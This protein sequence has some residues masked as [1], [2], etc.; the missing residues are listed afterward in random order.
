[1][2]YRTGRTGSV[3]N[4]DLDPYRVWYRSG[5]LYVVGLDHKSG[6]IRTFA[7]DRIRELEI[8]DECFEVPDSFDFDTYIG[9]S[10]GV[11]ADQAVRVRILFEP[12]WVTYVEERNWHESQSFKKAPGGKIEL[13]MD[14]GS[15]PDLRGWIL[16]FGSGAEVL[17]PEN[18]RAEVA[19]ELENARVR[20]ES[21]S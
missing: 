1:M 19:R 13:S 7:V 3:A 18:L 5:G 6:E 20:Y 8:A 11:I 16:S 10:F 14:V 12:D 2:R 9:S 17:E 4:R 21:A 15:T